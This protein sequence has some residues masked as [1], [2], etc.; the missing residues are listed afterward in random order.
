VEDDDTTKATRRRAQR[1]LG[2][3][4]IELWCCASAEAA[5]GSPAV[6]VWFSAVLQG[7]TESPADSKPV[8]QS[9]SLT[10]A[11][12]WQLPRSSLRIRDHINSD[13]HDGSIECKRSWIDLLSNVPVIACREESDVRS[14]YHPARVDPNPGRSNI[15]PVFNCQRLTT[16]TRRIEP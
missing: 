4:N 5:R 6:S 14:H 8:F 16:S 12:D 13:R 7:R 3:N 15:W 1:V 9:N 10:F 11:S 2:K